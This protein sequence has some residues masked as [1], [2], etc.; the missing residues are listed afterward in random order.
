MKYIIEEKKYNKGDTVIHHLNGIREHG[1]IKSRGHSW[2]GNKMINKY[3]INFEGRDG[4]GEWCLESNTISIPDYREKRLKK[5][6][7]D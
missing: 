2:N 3:Y 6:L 4:K 1:V 5:I 7:N